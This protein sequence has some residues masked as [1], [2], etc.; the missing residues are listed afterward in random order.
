[1]KFEI[2]KKEQERFE[3]MRE[4]IS[5]ETIKRVHDNL[6]KNKNRKLI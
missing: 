6:H 5:D 2:P 1:M 4:S 3:E